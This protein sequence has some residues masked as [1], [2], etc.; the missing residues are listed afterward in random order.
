M[1]VIQHLGGRDRRIATNSRSA[2]GMHQDPILKIKPTPPS[3]KPEES[4]KQASGAVCSLPQV[5][6]GWGSGGRRLSDG[7]LRHSF[8]TPPLGEC[9]KEMDGR[10]LCSSCILFIGPSHPTLCDRNN[11]NSAGA[12]L[13]SFSEQIRQEEAGRLGLNTVDPEVGTAG[14]VLVSSIGQLETVCF[15]VECPAPGVHI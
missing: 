10:D 6:K 11:Q 7:N 14:V 12:S 13:S 4:S 3:T 1:P 9:F 15:R 5:S 2:R 8:S